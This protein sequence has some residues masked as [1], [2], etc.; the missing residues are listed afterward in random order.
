MK[1]KH[2]DWYCNCRYKRKS[3]AK[4]KSEMIVDQLSTKSKFCLRVPRLRR[5]QR[6]PQ[7]P[8]GA[9]FLR[10]TLVFLFVL[11]LY[12]RLLSPS[13]PIQGLSGGQPAQVPCFLHAYRVL[14]AHFLQH[15]MR[16]RL[17]SVRTVLCL[18]Q[19]SVLQ[20]MILLHT[21]RRAQQCESSDKNTK[22]VSLQIILTVFQE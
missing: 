2:N 4:R 15:N 1:L 21:R 16:T 12:R 3:Q 20:N 9:S 14:L 11:S 5:R 13:T 22:I 7:P 8:E 10:S 17:V 18:W 19:F 6:R